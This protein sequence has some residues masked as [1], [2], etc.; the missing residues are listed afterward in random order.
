MHCRTS[1]VVGTIN[2]NPELSVGRNFASLDISASP[3]AKHNIAYLAIVNELMGCGVHD[4]H[5]LVKDSSG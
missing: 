4:K 2:V 5:V 1:I 3:I